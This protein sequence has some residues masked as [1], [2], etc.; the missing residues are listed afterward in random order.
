MFS[1]LCGCDFLNRGFIV[2]DKCECNCANQTSRCNHHKVLCQWR[3]LAGIPTY[4]RIYEQLNALALGLKD[5]LVGFAYG[6][7]YTR[8]SLDNKESAMVTLA[9]LA[10]KPQLN[11]TSI[12]L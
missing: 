8:D 3:E 12:L 2:V 10:T 5:Y 9:A 11:F 7:I 4:T 6:E 1:F